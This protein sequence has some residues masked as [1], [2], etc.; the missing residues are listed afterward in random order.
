M[1]AGLDDLWHVVCTSCLQ[2]AFVALGGHVDY[3]DLTFAGMLA[4]VNNIAWAAGRTPGVAPA[5]RFHAPFR[6]TEPEAG[7]SALCQDFAGGIPL[8]RLPACGI[9]VRH[10]AFWLGGALLARPGTAPAAAYAALDEGVRAAA[11]QALLHPAWP[12][13]APALAKEAMLRLRPRAQ[14]RQPCGEGA[15]WVTDEHGLAEALLGR[16]L[17]APGPGRDA[18]D[19]ALASLLA[20]EC[21]EEGL[22]ASDL[23]PCLC[24]ALVERGVSEP[25]A[26]SALALALGDAVGPDEEAIRDALEPYCL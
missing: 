24:R 26:L 4:T 6:A 15:L 2:A 16:W 23:R 12:A 5:P 7:T 17:A 20:E 13:Q 21:P 3:V 10:S 8:Y 25:V 18:F 22:E 11:A 19:Q 14:R 1:I 9:A